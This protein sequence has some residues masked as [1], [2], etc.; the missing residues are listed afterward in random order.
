MIQELDSERHRVKDGVIH[1]KC[2]LTVQSEKREK[3]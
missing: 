2:S 3:D 1:G